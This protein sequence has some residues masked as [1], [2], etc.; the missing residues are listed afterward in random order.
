MSETP[1]NDSACVGLWTYSSYRATLRKDGQFFAVVSPNGNDALHPNDAVRLIE[2]LQ[3]GEKATELQREL[4]AANARVKELEAQ[5][6][7]F[8]QFDGKDGIKCMV[9]VAKE[10]DQLKVDL[11]K[12]RER[13]RT[14]WNVYVRDIQ[15]NDCDQLRAQLAL[16]KKCVE[17]L[18]SITLGV[19]MFEHQ[20]T[21]AWKC[22][23]A[24][25]K[26]KEGK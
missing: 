5:W 11:E 4:K 18:R 16:A 8:K 22:L 26:F 6:D 15:G 23:A 24:Y 7:Y 13:F 1:V 12:E 25:D 10:R 3:R 14:L 19:E 9:E 17:A 2:T 21:P 20:W